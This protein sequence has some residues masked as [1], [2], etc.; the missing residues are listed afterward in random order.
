MIMKNLIRCVVLPAAFSV[1][2]SGCGAGDVYID[3]PA[4]EAVGINLNEKEPEADVPERSGLVMPP[5]TNKLPAPDETTTASAP[6]KDWPVDAE[7]E[8]KRKEK[9]EAAAREEYCKNGKWEGGNIDEFEKN[10]GNEQRCQSGFL[11]AISKAVGGGPAD[12]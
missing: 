1:G 10:I 5:S 4:L 7:V 6:A 8:K 11:Q 3:A 12:Q 9:A 2:V